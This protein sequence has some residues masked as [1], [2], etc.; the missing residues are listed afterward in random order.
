LL[1]KREFLR[2]ILSGEKVATIRPLWSR[3]ASLEVG[4]IYSARD[5]WSQK[6]KTYVVITGKEIKRLSEVTLEEVRMVGL[7]SLEHLRVTWLSCYGYWDPNEPVT[8]FQLRL[9]QKSKLPFYAKKLKK[10]K[11]IKA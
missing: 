8:V 10:L 3:T 7:R 2:R 9:A 6:A 4:R 5:H 11:S 1:F